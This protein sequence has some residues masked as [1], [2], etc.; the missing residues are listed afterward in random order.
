MAMVL[1]AALGAAIEELRKTVLEMKDKV[2]KRHRPALDRLKDTLKSIEPLLHEMEEL[3]RILDRP[4][5][6]TERLIQFMMSGR[7][8]VLE[9]S[10]DQWRWT[11]CW[12][13]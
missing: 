10:K 5:E 4:T 13:A 12:Q 1:N 3:N 11:R 2:V 9:R 6:E 8:L 7:Q